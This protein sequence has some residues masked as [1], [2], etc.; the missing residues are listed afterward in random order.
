MARIT[1]PPHTRQQLVAP[2]I[3]GIICVTA[4]TT[5]L[6]LWKQ[7]RELWVYRLLAAAYTLLVVSWL[8]DYHERGQ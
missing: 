4:A 6:F 7:N 3:S 8:R 2:L 1:Y 5:S